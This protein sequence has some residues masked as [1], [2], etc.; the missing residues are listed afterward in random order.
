MTVSAHEL[1]DEGQGDCERR[2]CEKGGT[3][4]RETVPDLVAD[5]TLLP[6]RR[7]R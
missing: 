4:E 2:G 6:L 1:G 7:L 5:P 3:R